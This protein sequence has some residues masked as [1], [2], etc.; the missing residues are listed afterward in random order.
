MFIYGGS[1][2]N[3]SE[4]Y[5]FRASLIPF[6][7]RGYL[8]IK[9]QV[10]EI[11]CTNH[12]MFEV[13]TPEKAGGQKEILGAHWIPAFDGGSLSGNVNHVTRNGRGGEE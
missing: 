1:G 12:Q 10:L 3:F 13:V 9:N 2:G 6:A 7:F 8:R 4:I 11:Y 5:N